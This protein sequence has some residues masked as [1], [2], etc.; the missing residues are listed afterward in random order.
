MN[1]KKTLLAGKKPKSNIARSM[2]FNIFKSIAAFL[3]SD[4]GKLIIGVDDS[5]MV[6]G[7]KEIEKSI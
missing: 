5:G 6:K 3:N 4:G 7:I 2:V 1:L